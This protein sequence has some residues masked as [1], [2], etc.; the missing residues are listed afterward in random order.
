MQKD[1]T[2]KKESEDAE[3]E[4]DFFDIKLPMLKKLSAKFDEI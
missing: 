3:N 1:K 4:L 2:Q